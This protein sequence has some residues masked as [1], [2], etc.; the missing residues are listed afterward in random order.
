M[1][2]GEEKEGRKREGRAGYGKGTEEGNSE[3]EYKGRKRTSRN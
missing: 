1:R 2:K 3:T